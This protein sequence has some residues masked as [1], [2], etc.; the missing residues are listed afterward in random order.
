MRSPTM[1]R[2]TCEVPAA[3]V[4][5]M[6]LNHAASCS[7]LPSGR[8]SLPVERVAAQRGPVEHVHGQVAEGLGVFGE[9]ELEHRPAYPGDAGL[10]RLGHVALGERPQG[11][12]GRHQ[13]PD[14]PR[15]A[16][17]VEEAQ[18]ARHPVQLAQ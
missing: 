13:V 14:A 8:P 2:C 17:V 12:E 6:A 1:L 5:E 18:P 4:E 11:V 3:M 16:G 9:G 15:Q 10:G 7:S